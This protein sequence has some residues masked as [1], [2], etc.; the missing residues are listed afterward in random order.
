MSM[1]PNDVTARIAVQDCC[2]AQPHNVVLS[3]AIG[4]AAAMHSSRVQSSSLFPSIPGGLTVV[5]AVPRLTTALVHAVPS[6]VR[7]SPE[8][9]ILTFP[10]IAVV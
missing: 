10:V 2:V 4:H 8:D 9:L 1:L 6:S 3:L 5:S 7:H